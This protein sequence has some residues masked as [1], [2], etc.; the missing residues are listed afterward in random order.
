[1]GGMLGGER[2]EGVPAFVDALLPFEAPPEDPALSALLTI[3]LAAP[4][5]PTAPP[6]C[7]STQERAALAEHTEGH[8][9]QTPNVAK[10]LDMNRCSVAGDSRSARD[11]TAAAVA[12][13]ALPAAADAQDAAAASSLPA[14]S[15]SAAAATKQASVAEEYRSRKSELLAEARRHVGVKSQRRPRTFSNASRALAHDLAAARREALSTQQD[16]PAAFT[17]TGDHT[18]SHR[19]AWHATD[20]AP[21]P[22]DWICWAFS[23]FVA[24]PGHRPSPV[25]A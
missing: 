20:R 8:A 3:G 2:A 17:F 25:A 13:A 15:S 24:A 19:L 10:M 12:S 23:F 21:A 16:R 18:C 1:M 22:Y 7:V 14:A 11:T 5:Q 9:T 6:E 4:T